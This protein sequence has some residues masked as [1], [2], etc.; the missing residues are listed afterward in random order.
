MSTESKKAEEIV[1]QYALGLSTLDLE[2]IAFILHPEFKFVYR[3]KNGM[4]HG[5]RTDIRY[6]GHLFKTFLAMKREGLSI[7]TD[8][9]YY[10][11]DNS[12]VLCIKILPLHDRR[13]IFP[14]DNQLI[15]DVRNDIPTG[16]VFMLPRI[17]NGLLAKIECYTSMDSFKSNVAGTFSRLNS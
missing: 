4:G 5:I 7:R 8:F 12:K 6:I 14:M 3:I 9:F 2:Q 17:K 15:Q 10:D 13:I 1:R 11:V 16:D